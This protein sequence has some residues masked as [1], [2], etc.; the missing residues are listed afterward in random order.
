MKYRIDLLSLVL[1]AAILAGIPTSINA[2]VTQE[3]VQTPYLSTS[4]RLKALAVDNNGNIYAAGYHNASTV[5][6]NLLTKYDSAGNVLWSREYLGGYANS[7][8]ISA[9]GNVIVTGLMTIAYAPDGTALWA[10]P[11]PNFLAQKVV[12]DEFNNIYIFGLDQS[13]NTLATMKYDSNGI[14]QWTASHSAVDIGLAVTNPGLS[15]ERGIC[16]SNGFVY[17]TATDMMSI[18][19][20]PS[21]RAIL[22]LKYNA[23]SG[24]QVWSALYTHANKIGQEGTDI[25]VDEA[26]SVYVTGSVHKKQG[27]AKNQDWVTL[28]YN[29][30]GAQVWATL[31]DGSGADVINNQTLT[32]DGPACIT[33]DDSGNPCVAG[34]SY[35]KTGSF[36][37]QDM[38]V[39]KYNPNGSLL[40]AK[41][42]DSPEHKD[43]VIYSITTSASGS[44]YAAGMTR[45]EVLSGFSAANATTL[46][47]NSAGVF[48]LF[49]TYDGGLN[50]MD[51][52]LSVRLDNSGNVYTTGMAANNGLLI[53]YSQTGT[54]K[55]S[56]DNR[57]SHPEGFVLS[58]NYPNPFNPATT[59]EY[60]L[61]E[62]GP[63]ILK[64]F[65]M[66]GTEVA[67]LVN[68]T[69]SAGPHTV[70]FNAQNLESGMYTY[71]LSAAGR[72]MSRKMSLL[73]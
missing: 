17:V 64:I 30:A 21:I 41:T 56:Q 26:G 25:D 31:Y 1:F 50:H 32:Y 70:M 4:M 73:K 63:V 23:T 69:Q 13:Q 59:I 16:Y 36:T 62:D 24:A 5:M 68:G 44:I 6:S 18:P 72:M 3:W 60:S 58:Q 48:Q 38:A 53:K 2:Q 7:V 20:K 52:A 61:T 65:N 54:P 19:G 29:S 57:R 39:V 35:T 45:G 40:W 15:Y 12:T 27:S 71:T 66:L 8:A 37:S 67:T 9:N 49:G 42:Y 46:K 47:Y 10:Q 28:K 14:L 34:T 33:L 55:E 51:I 43:D 22:T 11:V